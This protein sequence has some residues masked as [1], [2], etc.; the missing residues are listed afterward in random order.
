MKTHTILI[1]T[2][3]LMM[4]LCTSCSGDDDT[5]DIFS[6]TYLRIPDASFETILM[7]EWLLNPKNVHLE[8][9][10]CNIH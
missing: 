6:N 1:Y 7:A 8:L 5:K 10:N 2:T 4:V 3:I 9:S